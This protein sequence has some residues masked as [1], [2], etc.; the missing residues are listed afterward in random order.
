MTG[1]GLS[2]LRRLAGL[3]RSGRSGADSFFGGLFQHCRLLVISTKLA[4]CWLR[5]VTLTATSSGVVCGGGGLVTFGGGGGGSGGGW[6]GSSTFTSGLAAISGAA[7]AGVIRYHS[8][9]GS[10]Y[11]LNNTYNTPNPL[12][13]VNRNTTMRLNKKK[14]TDL[15]PRK[16]VGDVSQFKFR[17]KWMTIV[18]NLQLFQVIFKNFNRTERVENLCN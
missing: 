1:I 14:K 12:L 17:R 15:F 3:I 11:L 6:T 2:L 8:L 5:L 13:L 10:L 4:R 16:D 9:K 18:Q 7:S